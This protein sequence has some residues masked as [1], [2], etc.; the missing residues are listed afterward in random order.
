MLGKG[1]QQKKRKTKN[2]CNSSK[3]TNGQKMEMQNK[4][5]VIKFQ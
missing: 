3:Q 1:I 5:K 2:K 4:T